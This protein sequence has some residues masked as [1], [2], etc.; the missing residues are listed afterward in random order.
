MIHIQYSSFLYLR[1]QCQKTNI[2]VKTD[3]FLTDTTEQDLVETSLIT[4]T[5]CQRAALCA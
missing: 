3:I 1:K 2:R 5:L 4:V